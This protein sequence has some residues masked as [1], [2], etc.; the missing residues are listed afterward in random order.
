MSDEIQ[1]R[2]ESAGVPEK[3]EPTMSG[4]VYSPDV[5]ILETPEAVVVTADMPGV[6]ENS[7]NVTLEDD[8]LSIEGRP[9][10]DAPA[11]HR[12]AWREYGVGAFVRSFALSSEVDRNGIEAR[13]KDGVLRVRLPKAPEA[14][15][16]KI[17][18]SAG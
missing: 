12:L 8:I 15:A 18:V 14:K 4:D 11:G 5:D 2:K 1:V 13:I 3:A 6:D 10:Y 7:L 16:R 9:S 17:A